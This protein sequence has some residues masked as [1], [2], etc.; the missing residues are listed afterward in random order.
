MADE[1]AKPE[2]L[3][4]SESLVGG[5]RD[6]SREDEASRTNGSSPTSSSSFP[7]SLTRLSP[8]T[9]VV[10]QNG[11][12]VDF[13]IKTSTKMSKVSARLRSR[14]STHMQPPMEPS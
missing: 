7:L 8:P 1:V 10:H 3:S 2:G 5:T 13:K 9:E 6:G 11:D 14:E 12:E 4:I